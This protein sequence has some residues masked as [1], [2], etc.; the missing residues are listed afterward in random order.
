MKFVSLEPSTRKT[1][2]FKIEFSEPKKIFHFGLKNGNTYI[3]HHDDLKRENYL[4]RHM[5]NEDWSEVNSG[6][7]SAFILWGPS[8]DLRINLKAFLRKYGIN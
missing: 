7:L 1:K 5:V 3:D 2:R 4:K 6:S 8:S